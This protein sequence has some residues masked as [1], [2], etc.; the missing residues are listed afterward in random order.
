MQRWIRRMKAK[1]R[2]KRVVLALLLLIAAGGAA[3]A[4]AQLAGAEEDENPSFT[5]N[6]L[7]TTNRSGLDVCVDGA[8]GL[9]ASDSLA[10][11]VDR[12][13]DAALGSIKGTELWRESFGQS[14]VAI[15]CPPP[16]VE[17][18][19]P[20][21]P[22]ERL[23]RLGLGQGVQA[24]SP[25]RL[26]VYFLPSDRYTA[27][28]TQ[29][30]YASVTAEHVCQGDA[31]FGTTRALYVSEAIAAETLTAAILD[32]LGLTILEPEPTLDWHACELGTPEPWCARYEGSQD[33]Q[34]QNSGVPEGLGHE[35]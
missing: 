29:E 31:C 3:A 7:I 13:M 34:Q 8:G 11:R 24:P 1:L 28:F 18:G 9:A 5:Y 27:T 15:G 32:S 25:Y 2:S 14:S 17:V 16:T 10:D 12:S 26:F 33:D 19:S 6:G 35:P 21:R 4:L 22:L 30:P 23:E 20:M